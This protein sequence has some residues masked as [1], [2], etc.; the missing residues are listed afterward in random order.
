MKIGAQM[1]TVREYCK[2]LEDF[3]ET[4]KK[5]ADI[6]Y[7]TVQVS[8]TCSY[9]P[10][11]LK[12]ELDKNGLSC[13]ITHTAFDGISEKTSESIA[14]HKT[15]NCKYI[16]LGCFPANYE[17]SLGGVN[18]FVAKVLS[19]SKEI[20]NSGCYFM[21][22]N[23]AFEF[24]K[25]DDGSTIMEHLINV[26]PNEYM[27]FTLDTHWVKVGGCDPVE[28]LKMLKG[29]TPCVHYKDLIYNDE[30]KPL[31]AP[32]GGGTLDFDAI[33]K[34]SIDLGVEY[35]LVEQ[36]DCYGKDP[37]ECLKNS[38]DYLKSMGLS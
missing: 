5:I 27:G 25:L 21:Y 20:A 13:V 26:I 3:S 9:D 16:G 29:R 32:V 4:L 24:D 2:S 12:E 38:Y 30:N 10:E 15:L 11:W 37:F 14:N 36:D 31:F 34:A 19:F 35:A 33:I 22:H 7:T 17:R 23:H 1:F 18:S 8:G 28:Y 6:G